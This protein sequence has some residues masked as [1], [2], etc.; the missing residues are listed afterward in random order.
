MS[1]YNERKKLSDSFPE[2]GNVRAKQAAAFLGIG[3]STLWAYASA[4]DG[5][6][7]K[8]KKLS[9]RVSVWDASYIRDIALNGLEP[10]GSE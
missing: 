7:K 9:S 5:R 4:N 8:P 3:L 6:I 2:S 10:S 1:I